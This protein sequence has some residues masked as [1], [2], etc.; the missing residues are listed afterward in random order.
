MSDW[1]DIEWDDDGYPTEDS[2]E[3]VRA[4][5]FDFQQAAPWLR[6][7][8]AACAQNNCSFYAE[9]PSQTFM[10]EPCTLVS[11]STGGWSGAEELIA[12]IEGRF[13]CGYYMLSWRRG[14]H[15][16]FEFLDGQ[17]PPVE[18]PHE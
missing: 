3:A 13:D 14:G 16:E 9:Q 4:L 15:Y 12:L 17:T 6:H 7:N 10:E 8:L 5:P 11:F 2:I 1:P 18:T